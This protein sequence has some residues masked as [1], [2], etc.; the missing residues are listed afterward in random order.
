L[1]PNFKRIDALEN[2]D[3]IIVGAG[4]SGIN[5]ACHLRRYCP[6]LTFRIFEA[7]SRIGGTW[8]LF[9]Y[10]GVRSDSDMF[11]LGFSHFPW[12]SG[13]A[14][15]DGP[16]ILKYIEET[17]RENHL[18]Q[19]ISFSHR[20]LAANWSSDRSLWTVSIQHENAGEL[21]QVSGRFLF[22][23]TGYYD[24]DKGYTPEFKGFADYRGRCAHPQRWPEDLDYQGK[25]VVVIGS[26]ATAV[27]LVPELAKK[28]HHVTML[29]RSPTY[30][31]NLPAEDSIDAF[32]L[33]FL[34]KGLA[35]R[36]LR[37]RY[38]GLSM[39]FFL[40]SRV[41]PK[42]T[43]AILV[44]RV[45]R[46]LGAS[47]DV[48]TH[49]WP[50]YN[51]WDQRLCVVPDG[52]LFHAIKSGKVAM[53]TAE[54]DRFV[55]KGI[56]L[57]SGEALEADLVVT[58]TGFNLKFAGGMAICVDDDQITLP[59]RV[60]F[61]GMML[62]GIPNLA[63]TFGYTNASWTLKSDLI[64]RYICRT[65][66]YMNQNSWKVCIPRRFSATSEKTAAI[67]L[68]SGYVLR[69]I[70]QFPK[71]GRHSPWKMRQNYIMDLIGLRLRPIRD[72]ELEF[73]P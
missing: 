15:A 12:D 46:E 65:L 43:R 17:A 19:K 21:S 49:F 18:Q 64:C 1:I 55:E 14:I 11:T 9:R 56:R 16:S 63:F 24:Y 27:T 50:R 41:S 13:K 6:N 36:F 71:Q 3:V 57:K 22:L 42:L 7:R 52:D 44:G 32:V 23:C 61:K 2:F 45:E 31:I 70:D 4:L 47:Y 28:A 26:G 8:D 30:M 73:R 54:I 5:A 29:Q 68:T 33:R 35:H 53:E 10:P 62:D 59:D 67:E 48:R 66:L 72:S 58:A 25:K 39:G 51:P 34:P 69:S 38:I 40:L 20:V 60:I 37:W